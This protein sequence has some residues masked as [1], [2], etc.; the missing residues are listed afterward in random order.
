[1]YAPGHISSSKK[2]REQQR[3]D[4]E[5]DAFEKRSE[6]LSGGVPKQFYLRG[7]DPEAE[8]SDGYRGL[9]PQSKGGSKRLG[10]GG[11][12]DS[13]S[14]DPTGADKYLGD[15]GETLLRSVS[16][17]SLH[18]K[19]SKRTLDDIRKALKGGM[20]GNTTD[21]LQFSSRPPPSF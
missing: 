2:R 20:R 18:K 5:A 1:M 15:R 10:L 7:N 16:P 13:L 12:E 14:R 11:P 6:R 3:I 4:E 8:Q 19:V 21:S 17:K 9:L